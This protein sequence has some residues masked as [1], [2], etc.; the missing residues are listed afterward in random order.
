MSAIGSNN[1]FKALSREMQAL[2]Y[3]VGYWAHKRSFRVYA[4]GGFVRD[5]LL[6][7]ENR[8]IDMVVDGSAIEFAQSLV[9]IMPG[10]LK[11]YEKFGT[12]TLLLPKGIIF[13]MVT[14]RREFYAYPG[15]LP[16]IEKSTLRN[17][18][19][20]RD[21]T[22]N[23]MA[24]DLNPEKFGRLYDYFGG[25]SDLEEGLIR[26]L[27]R[28][29]FVDDPLRII[30]ALRFEQR[31]NF[32]LENET[33]QLLSSAVSCRLLEKVSKERLYNEVRFIFK[34]PSPLNI[35]LRIK[36]MGFF[37]MLFPRVELDRELE[38]RLA[39]LQ[40][41]VEEHSQ[42]SLLTG[43]N[44]FL[45]YLAAIIYGLSWHDVK[46]LSYRFRLKKKERLALVALLE[47]VPLALERIKAKEISPSRIYHLF[48]GMPEEGML[49]MLALS[50]DR[51]VEERVGYYYEKLRTM[52]PS[53][54]GKN[55]LDM[56]MKPGPEIKQVLETLH[57][58]VLDGKVKGEEEEYQYVR[59]LL[60]DKKLLDT[61]REGE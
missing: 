59:G 57:E 46:Y 11:S 7:A 55:L 43:K 34:E 29:S 61:E 24:C 17:D 50:S 51:V 58:A 19:Y 49:L 23:T 38:E 26:V 9:Q 45:L 42:K 48:K 10:R 37:N 5:L 33:L 3:H 35:L 1:I 22:I 47:R 32:S 52:G 4:V 2:V 41:V 18:L 25:K 54:S 15:A 60:Q 40:R 20:R 8:D 14:A 44:L 16:D 21:F 6:G 36:E 31:F 27:Y 12:A 39:K 56:G 28:L 53:L 30:R 13:D